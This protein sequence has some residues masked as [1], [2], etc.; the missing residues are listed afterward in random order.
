MAP[1]SSRLAAAWTTFNSVMPAPPSPF[2]SA[3]R[4]S[5][6]AITSAKEPN[7]ASK[8]LASGLTSR[9]GSARNKSSS[10]SS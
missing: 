7:F 2:T 9:R 10:N 1:R 5:G 3:S 4:A 6:A 8:V